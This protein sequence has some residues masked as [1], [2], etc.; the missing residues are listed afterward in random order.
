[1]TRPGR[2]PNSRHVCGQVEGHQSIPAVSDR[3]GPPETA[4][5]R[6]LA[7]LDADLAAVLVVRQH[8]VHLVTTGVGVDASRLAVVVAAQDQED[9]VVSGDQ[10]LPDLLGAVLVV[11][12]DAFQI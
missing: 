1:M 9:L 4:W 6:C 12:I 11:G 2:H 10:L 8:L 5:A 3:S 7:G